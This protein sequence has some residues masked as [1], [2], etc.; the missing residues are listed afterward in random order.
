M[1]VVDRGLHYQNN[2][3]MS[4]CRHSSYTAFFD[5]VPLYARQLRPPNAVTSPPSTR[6]AEGNS[7]AFFASITCPFSSAEAASASPKVIN[8]HPIEN[9]V[10]SISSCQQEQ[11]CCL[12]HSLP[13]EGIDRC[14]NPF[15][16]RLLPRGLNEWSRAPNRRPLESTV[17]LAVQCLQWFLTDS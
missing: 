16:Y 10:T 17:H 4:A 6:G 12:V 2:G 14:A 3:R 5:V 9:D 15:R 7:L 8:F 11:K 13:R 1:P